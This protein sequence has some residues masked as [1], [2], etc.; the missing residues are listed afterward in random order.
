MSD[1]PFDDL[2]Q[3]L[4]NGQIPSGQAIAFPGTVQVPILRAPPAMPANGV[5]GPSSQYDAGEVSFS[6]PLR[7]SAADLNYLLG[8]IFPDQ[9]VGR[10]I[11]LEL[12]NET[13]NSPSSPVRLGLYLRI[14]P[15]Q[16]PVSAPA[17]APN[18][19]GRLVSKALITEATGATEQAARK[20]LVQAILAMGVSLRHV[21]TQHLVLSH[22]YRQPDFALQSIKRGI[23]GMAAV[24]EVEWVE[25]MVQLRPVKKDGMPWFEARLEMLLLE[26]GFSGLPKWA[27]IVDVALGLRE[28]QRVEWAKTYGEVVRFLDIV[29]TDLDM[30]EE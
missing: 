18:D 5:A 23:Q 6:P 29:Q 1:N 9:T 21:T 19:T 22:L 30:A 3:I 11:L 14:P 24:S 13:P 15:Q 10:A 7:W 25:R 4:S 8:A 16:R 28:E 2:Y 12:R 26:G 27:S 20:A 17:A